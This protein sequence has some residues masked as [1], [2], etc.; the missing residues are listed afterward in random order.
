VV[1]SADIKKEA[2][3]HPMMRPVL[4]LT[5]WMEGLLGRLTD[6]QGKG[7]WEGCTAVYLLQKMYDHMDAGRTGLEAGASTEYVRKHFLDASNYS[8]MIADN[9]CREHE[10]DGEYKKRNEE[11]EWIS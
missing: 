2:D 4:V 9:Y 7:G 6:N 3:K 8:M 11:G 10:A 5:Q 1:T